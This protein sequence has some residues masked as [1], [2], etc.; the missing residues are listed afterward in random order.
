[1]FLNLLSHLHNFA[2][3]I[4][5]SASRGSDFWSL[6]NL[7]SSVLGAWSTCNMYQILSSVVTSHPFPHMMFHLEV[8]FIFYASWNVCKS[9]SPPLKN[10]L[11][12]RGWSYWLSNYRR[13]HGTAGVF[14]ALG[15][16]PC[17][18]YIYLFIYFSMWFVECGP[19]AKQQK[20]TLEPQHGWPAGICFHHTRR[21]QSTVSA[22]MKSQHMGK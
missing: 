5:L 8:S 7:Q 2:Y 15:R 16:E 22:T 12:F 19:K 13:R 1:M 11:F 9:S 4:C 10:V 14:K 3:C 17:R 20:S 6:G 18:C 21:S